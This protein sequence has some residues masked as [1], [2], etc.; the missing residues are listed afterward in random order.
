MVVAYLH[1]ATC[2]SCG[3]RHGL[4]LDA[5]SGFVAGTDYEYVCPGTGQRARHQPGAAHN[6]VKTPP[7]GAVKA[8]RVH[9]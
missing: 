4:Y 3:R 2:Q 1:A 8:R 9:Q 6:W 7:L 5:A